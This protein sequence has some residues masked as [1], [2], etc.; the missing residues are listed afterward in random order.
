MADIVNTVKDF[1]QPELLI[2]IPVLY[3]IGYGIRKTEKF[4]NNNIPVILGIIG[5]IVSALYI[6][7]NMTGYS[8]SEI[9]IAMFTAITQGILT[10]GGAVYVDQLIKQHKYKNDTTNID[11]TETI[12]VPPKDSTGE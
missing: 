6:A 11:T 9:M 3:F 5:V 4:N 10:A 7:A 1:I 12:T 2:L 8:G